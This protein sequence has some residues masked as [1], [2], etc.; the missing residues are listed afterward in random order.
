MRRLEVPKV[1]P[2]LVPFWSSFGS[3]NGLQNGAKLGPKLAKFGVHFWIPFFGGFG[4][5]W[6]P[7]GSLLGPH[8]A[9]LGGLW[10]PKALKNLRFFKVFGNAAFWLYEPLDG[11]LGLILAPFWADLVPK[12]PQN[13]PKSGP[14]SD[15]KMINKTT[16]K[17]TRNLQ[18]LVPEI[19]PKWSQMAKA[20]HV[21][22][23]PELSW[24]LLVPTCLQDG[25]E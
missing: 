23:L 13:W 3:Q 6:V 25:L 15:Q 20:G 17:N 19:G 14:K 7:L 9:L 1:V 18:I 22:I 8:A 21:K 11:P 2:F 16:P 24:K 12:L 10:T 5:L 4:A